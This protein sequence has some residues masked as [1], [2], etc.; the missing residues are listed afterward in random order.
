MS[1]L[2]CVSRVQVVVDS[3]GFHLA[4]SSLSCISELHA[5]VVPL[6]FY[7]TVSTLCHGSVVHAVV[8]AI[9]LSF[10]SESTFPCFIGARFSG[11]N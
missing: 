4:V 9:R 5:L 2:A 11:S 7:S 6:G 1:L 3:L 8:L 10:S